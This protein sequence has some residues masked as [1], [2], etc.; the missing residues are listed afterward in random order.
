MGGN[1][2]RVLAIDLGASSGRGIVFESD[3]KSM[4]YFEVYRFDNNGI[5][6]DGT[7]RWDIN[8]IFAEI[9]TCIELSNAKGIHLD[10]VGIDTWGV[11]YG[12]VSLDGTIKELP[13][14]YRDSRTAGCI[15]R[16]QI[17]TKRQMFDMAGISLNEFNTAY[18]LIAQQ[19]VNPLIDTD[20][21]LYIPYLL[22]YM[23]TGKLGCDSTIASTS[24]LYRD[25]YDKDFLS[26]LGLLSS[27]FAPVS[28][29]GSVLGNIHPH[30]ASMCKLDYE[31]PVIMTCGHDTACAIM[32]VMDG[33]KPLYISS[34]TW[35]LF[36]TLA[37]EPITTDVAFAEGYT[38]ERGFG[39]KV[40]LLKNIMG[41]W[42]IQECR[43]EW[44]KDRDISWNDIVEECKKVDEFK[45]FINVDD[46]LFNPPYNMEK[47]IID[48]VHTTQNIQLNGIGEVA[49]CF[50]NSL[51]MEYRYALDGLKNITHR[52]YD[53]LHIIGGG[54]RNGLLNQLVADCLNIKVVGGCVEAT[55]IGNALGQFYGLGMVTNM[56]EIY[57]LSQKTFEP[58][59]YI[60]SIDRQAWDIQYAKYLALKK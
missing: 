36:G 40:T 1:M 46:S 44:Q 53:T 56:Q 20:T 45:G 25:G 14:H 26:K 4:N 27:N 9:L 35:S 34:G 43:R 39:D 8:K 2:K 32:T 42:I 21:L 6:V 60:P 57:Q 17:Y 29:V 5:M 28:P 3:G 50:Y 37:D 12:V 7:L 38:N 19:Q 48:Y 11:D 41:M 59:T 13:Y 54:T 24:A 55:A 31:L 30:V 58:V 22:G 51:A 52:E 18:Q 10:S 16:E 23:L 15:E 33:E 47:R 49:R